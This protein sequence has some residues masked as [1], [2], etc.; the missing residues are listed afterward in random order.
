[1]EKRK[2]SQTPASEGVTSP[3]QRPKS[4]QPNSTMTKRP[5]K[6]NYRAFCPRRTPFYNNAFMLAPDG[7]VLCTCDHKK[8]NW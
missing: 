1:M 5:G 2:L 8:A 4:G 6:Q 7:E 3:V